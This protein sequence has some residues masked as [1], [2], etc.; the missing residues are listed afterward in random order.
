MLYLLYN[1]LNK[2]LFHSHISPMA[3]RQNTIVAALAGIVVGTLLG[4]GSVQYGEIVAYS[5]MNPNFAKEAG[6]VLRN[7]GSSY[8]NK[9]SINNDEG[10]KFLRRSTNSIRTGVDGTEGSLVRAAAPD[11]TGIPEHC[12]GLTRTRFNRC[13]DFWVTEGR[14]Y[15]TSE[16]PRF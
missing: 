9:R 4:A 12:V 16:V 10:K 15:R 6:G 1:I 3:N 2:H 8:I 14:Y 5:G 11:Y 7:S 13:V